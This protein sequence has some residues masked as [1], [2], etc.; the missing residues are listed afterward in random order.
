MSGQIPVALPSEFM[1]QW[2]NTESLP[3]RPLRTSKPKSVV[4][5]FSDVYEASRVTASG[6]TDT[7]FKS[8][9]QG[10]PR[11]L[12]MGSGTETYDKEKESERNVNASFRMPEDD[13]TRKYLDEMSS[14][15]A[16]DDMVRHRRDVEERGQR[17]EAQ[18]SVN[19][20]PEHTHTEKYVTMAD[21]TKFAETISRSQSIHPNDSASNVSFKPL[22][23]KR[24]ILQTQMTPIFEDKDEVEGTVIGGY[25]MSPQEKMIEVDSYSKINPV[26]G[27]PVIFTDSRLNFLTHIH[28]PLFKLLR[29][30]DGSYPSLNCLEVLMDSRKNWGDEPSTLLLETVLD[31]T[32]DSK[33]GIVK[34]NPFNIPVIEP[35]MLLDSR[36]MYMALDQLHR[37][38]EI[39][40]FN[41]MKF[42]TLPIFQSKYDSLRFTGVKKRDRRSSRTS[43][44][45]SKTN[46]S[47]SRVSSSRRGSRSNDNDSLLSRFLS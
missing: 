41:T 19:H 28:S 34:A 12:K 40:W 25:T 7:T 29:D 26:M 39:Q 42:V 4:S 27:L 44:G 43:S 16:F 36:I 46:S 30:E 33:T 24:Q 8:P 3:M 11:T 22:S 21:F 32:I 37:E 1:N 5:P 15:S 31:S 18:Q 38:F 13:L 20:S 14:E 23:P 9:R 17:Q 47:S 45:E 10:V 2:A 35:T 6:F